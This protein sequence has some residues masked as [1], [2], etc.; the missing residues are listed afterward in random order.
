LGLAATLNLTPR[1]AEPVRRGHPWVYREQVAGGA[2]DGDEV[3]LAFQGAVLARGLA[4]SAG[5]IAV[6]VWTRGD[7][8]IDEALVRRRLEYAVALRARAFDDARTDCYRVVNGEGDRTPGLVVDRYG[9]AAVVVLDDAALRARFAEMLP[10]IAD[11]LR[12]LGVRAVLLRGGRGEARSVERVS[13]EAVDMRPRVRE[14]GVPFVVDLEKGQKTGAF[15]DQRENRRRVGDLARGRRVLNLFSYAGGFSL[16]AALG[17]ATAI[18]SVDVAAQG[19]ATAQESFKLAGVSPSAHEFVTQ[20]CFAFLD[21]AA[22]AGRRWDLVVSDP[23]SFAPNAKSV[24][25]ALQAYRS[26]HRA[27]TAV[28][29][30]GGIFCAASCSSHVDQSAFASTLDD[31]ALESDTLRLLALFGAPCDHPSLPAFPEGRYLKFAVLG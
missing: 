2:Q 9:E 23:P 19:H 8:P 16:H 27:C 31:A 22:R 28:L 11:A 20:D 13:G 7:A 5:P 17:G 10:W 25:R 4:S 14:H 12:P 30:E 15:L 26:L 18:T 6:R 21:Q 3:R 29:A 24:P 1:A